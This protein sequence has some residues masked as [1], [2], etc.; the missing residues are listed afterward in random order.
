LSSNENA[1]NGKFIFEIVSRV[2]CPRPEGAQRRNLSAPE[3]G[4]ASSLGFISVAIS[5]PIVFKHRYFNLMF[6]NEHA[7]SAS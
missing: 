3:R 5:L 4:I 2:G 6:E 1:V 7:K